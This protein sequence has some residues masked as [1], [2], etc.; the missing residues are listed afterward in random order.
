[1]S[2]R[3]IRTRQPPESLFAEIAALNRQAGLGSTAV[4]VARR[5]RGL[6]GEDELLLAMDGDA[7]IGYA[8]LRLDHSLLA[9]V[10]P[11]V[12]AIVVDTDHRRRRVGRRLMAAA[13]TWAL[14]A[15][16]SRLLLRSEVVRTELQAFLAALGYQA[17]STCIDF[18]RDL[19]R[20]RFAEAPTQDL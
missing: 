1:M 10:T 5:V 11:E 13:E 3:I 8:H 18:V 16:H 12:A 14:D 9:D 4:E 20:A 6:S 2:L 7:L 17:H 15:G 19:E